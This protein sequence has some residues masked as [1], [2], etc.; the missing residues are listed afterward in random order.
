MNE[1]SSSNWKEEIK[2]LGKQA[3][4]IQD[5]LNLG[6]LKVEAEKL[7]ELKAK[8]KELNTIGAEIRKLNK[9]LEGIEDI[10]PIIKEIRQKRIERVRAERAI[11]KIEKE[12]FKK[13][14]Q[15]KI[16]EKKKNTPTFLG[17]GVSKFLKFSGEDS[18]K[19]QQQKLPIINNIQVLSEAT[20]L[21]REEILWLAYHRQTAK[22]DHY[23]RFKIP[24][25]KDG[26]RT[27]AS[28]KGKMRIAQ[29]WIRENILEK[30]PIH[31]AA[32]A[33]Q[34]ES[35]VVKNAEVHAGSELIIRIDLK[36]FFP[37][38]QFHRVRGLFHSFGYNQGMATVFALLC[39]DA[40]RLKAQLANETYFVALGERY[41]P[42][43]ATTSPMMT[44]LICKKLDNRLQKFCEKHQ[45]KYTRYADDLVFSTSEKENN[46]GKFLHTVHLILKEE[47]FQV[48]EEKTLI[49]RPHQRQVVTG[50]LVNEGELRIPRKNLRN[51]RAF[52]HQYALNGAEK[53]SE[54]LGKDATQYGKGYFSFVKM[55]NKNQAQKL[56]EQASWLG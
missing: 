37:S 9:E 7:E 40:M 32:T 28:P 13:I 38:I 4:E 51:F 14:R 20:N 15:E 24:K 36:D 44:N 17:K 39:T 19:L 18:E 27:I 42:Q 26:F 53:M 25:R 8:Y 34:S 11:R 2:V 54:T 23:S 55:V 52:L 22:I 56:L 1:A 46:L 16:K 12:E 33:F 5:M 31:S 6:F 21:S 43:G 3:F 10:T 45:W 29:S 41:L 47:N 50:I 48:N 35:S 30:L 49:S